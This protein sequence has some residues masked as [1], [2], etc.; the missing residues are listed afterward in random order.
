M[1]D[2]IIIGLSSFGAVLARELCVL[3]ENVLA[4]D[5]DKDIV[6]EMKDQVT[7]AIIADA[8]DKKILE[9]LVSDQKATV[10]VCL[11]DSME[12]TVMV[13]YYLRQLG[14]EKIISKANNCDQGKVLQLIGATE[15]VQP[16]KDMALRLA[17]RLHNPKLLDILPIGHDYAV[18]E[19]S[20]PK[21][22]VGKSLDDLKLRN[23][24]RINVLAIKT[25][26]DLVIVPDAKY[27]F[28]ESEVLIALGTPEDINKIIVAND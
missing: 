9:K 17:E 11:G 21:N 14:V 4:I 1:A 6:Q 5:E 23:D 28:Q 24:Y 3:G 8:T 15:I 7:Q 25:A 10:I 26:A 27:V 22:F 19:I 12:K 2:Y 13:V 16:E 20:I 18:M